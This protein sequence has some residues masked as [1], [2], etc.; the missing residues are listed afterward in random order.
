MN[1]KN[2]DE[3]SL[4]FKNEDVCRDMLAKS[5]WPDGKAVCP[6]CGEKGAYSYANGKWYK[7]KAKVCKARFS[8]TV[9]T[10]F[11]N[12]K[13]PLRTWY[14][15]IWLITAHKKGISSLQLSR[16]L[17]IGQKAA[18]FVLHRI[19][20][21]MVDKMPEKL[22]TIVE[23][24]ETWVG[25]KVA[26]MN[27]KKR[28]YWAERG[29]ENKTLV[30][31]MVE[32]GGKAKLKIIG[33]DSFKD[34]VKEHVDQSAVVFTDTHGSYV[35]LDQHF[36]AHE[37]VNHSLNEYKRGDVTTNSVEGF[38]ACFKRSL[39]GCYHQVSKKH[40][41]RYCVETAYRYTNRTITDK[42]RFQMT[43]N[44]VSGRLKWKDL[45]D[46]KKR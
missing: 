26:N 9:G 29:N 44:Q 17:G 10:M 37:S 23:V 43:I 2:Y 46:A 33:R 1:F 39:L 38:F 19:R 24:D 6:K 20:E 45:I 12:T 11:E 40:L 18:W 27:K 21:M 28:A 22:N 15:A 35:G 25:G 32:R 4:Y 8:V 5:R 34:V 13:L 7:C 36:E 41:E 30:M 31:G 14:L 42:E 3:A 16:D